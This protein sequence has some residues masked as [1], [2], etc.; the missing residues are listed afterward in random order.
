MDYTNLGLGVTNPTSKLHFKGTSSDN[1]TSSLNVENLAGTS[2]MYVRNDGNV[3]IGATSLTAKLHVTGV[4]LTLEAIRLTNVQNIA[5]DRGVM[6]TF[7]VPTGV[8][9]SRLGGFIKVAN[10]ATVDGSYMSFWTENNTTTTEKVRIDKTGNFGIGTTTPSSKLSVAQATVGTAVVSAIF[11]NTDYTATNRNFIKVF[12]QV[13]V[14]SSIS[15]LLGVDKDTNNIILNNDTASANHLVI[16]TLGRVGIGLTSPAAALHV[17][18]GDLIQAYFN[19]GINS[20]AGSSGKIQIGDSTI[21]KSYGGAFIFGSN[22]I[23]T[24][25]GN[26]IVGTAGN[27]YSGVYGSNSGDGNGVYGNAPGT[28]TGIVGNSASG[29]GGYFSSTTGYGLIVSS[30]KVGIGNTTPVAKLD[31]TGNGSFTQAIDVAGVNGAI[32]SFHG[33]INIDNNKSFITNGSMNFAL[34]QYSYYASSTSADIVNDFRTYANGTNL[35]TQK[36]TVANATK[37]AGTWTTVQTL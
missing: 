29:V 9:S 7:H 1:T 35:I 36:C 13:G 34:N 31:V 14:S 37:G 23:A 2:L 21:A 18:S 19:N 12:Q 16:T 3:G 32:S 15:A 25:V 6:Q 30:G 5:A 27:G 33:G 11:A 4:D 10:N 24:S 28:G 17:S 26:A 22:I 8:A 20:G